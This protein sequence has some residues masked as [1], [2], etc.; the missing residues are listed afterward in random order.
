MPQAIAIG[1]EAGAA[2]SLRTRSAH[3][4]PSRPRLRERAPVQIDSDIA[5]RPIS[6]PS[7]PPSAPPTTALPATPQPSYA[8]L[9]CMAPRSKTC[10]RHCTVRRAPP[11]LE[12]TPPRA[13]RD[14]LGAVR[15]V[16]RVPVLRAHRGAAARAGDRRGLAVRSGRH[17]AAIALDGDVAQGAGRGAATERLLPARLPRAW[18]ARAGQLSGP[19]HCPEGGGED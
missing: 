19:P 6:L 1:P 17:H 14:Q 9:G 11:P 5:C 18:F 3:C 12:H 7:A 13:L 15:A 16:G 8:Q 10:A 2:R 4:A